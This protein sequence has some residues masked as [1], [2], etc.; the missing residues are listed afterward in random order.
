MQNRHPEHLTALGDVIKNQPTSNTSGASHPTNEADN[1]GEVYTCPLCRDARFVHPTR[2]DGKPDYT[3]VIPCKCVEGK[4]ADKRRIRMLEDCEIPPRA[5]GWTFETFE[6][7]PGLEEAYDKALEFTEDSSDTKW[8][9]LMSGSDRGKTH[10]LFAICHRWLEEGRPARYA[11]VPDLL[12]ELRQGF[13]G[14]GDRSY[15]ARWRFFRNVPLL[16]LDDLG[17]ENKTPW[18]QE[19]LDTLID[20]RLRQGLALVVATNTPMEDL[21]FR[22]RSR[23]EREGRVIYIRAHDYH[24]RL[25]RKAGR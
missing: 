8:L 11:Y 9:V 20:Y 18:V 1:I 17:T 16:A 6:R 13:R 14:E 21:P 15:E 25:D 19:R 24:T 3:R 23:L 5:A 7:L 12:D 2:G 22:I 4:L 10:L